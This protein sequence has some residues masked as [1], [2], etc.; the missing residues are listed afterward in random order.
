MIHLKRAVPA[1]LL[2]VA[3]PLGAAAGRAVP[4]GP[5][6]V[7]VA[8]AITDPNLGPETPDR[9][10]LL[11]RLDVTY[12]AAVGFDAGM[13]AAL[14]QVDVAT[15]YPGSDRPATFTGPRLA[16][17]LEAAGAGGRMALPMGLDGYQVEISADLI[18]AHDPILATRLDGAPMAIGGLGPAMVVFPEVAD[19][20]LTEELDS[21]EV[22]STFFIATQ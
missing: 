2:C 9:L 8:G 21:L 4:E 1:L 16:A 14:P 11:S 5:V 19:P 15:V 18:A 10:T 13:L 3:L 7:T 12:E 22:W 20:E 6:L 17:V